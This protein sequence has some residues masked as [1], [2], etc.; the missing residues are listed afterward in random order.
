SDEFQ[1]LNISA[2]SWGPDNA[3]AYIGEHGDFDCELMVLVF[4]SHDF[5]DNMHHRKVVGEQTSWPKNQP[6]SATTD[7]LESYIIPKVNQFFG[8][9][10]YAYLD[11]FDDSNINSG[12]SKFFTYANEREIPFILH[13]HPELDEVK[14]GSFNAEGQELLAYLSGRN[15]AFINGIE[16]GMKEENYRDNIHLNASGQNQLFLNLYPAIKQELGVR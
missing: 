16:L 4:S 10:E 6:L 11:G 15:I 12:W 7:L 9:N 2:G 3:F 14:L 5:H 8:Q 13:L 1:V